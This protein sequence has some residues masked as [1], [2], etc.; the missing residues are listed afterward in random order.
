MLS[1]KLVFFVYHL[2]ICTGT[3]G[4]S[5]KREVHTQALL[6]AGCAHLNNVTSLCLSLLICKTNIK[7]NS[8]DSH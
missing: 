6:L 2:F 7:Y 3:E 1:Q 8:W 4:A 5:N